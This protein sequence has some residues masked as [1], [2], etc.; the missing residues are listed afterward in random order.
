MFSMSTDL[1]L[2]MYFQ[3]RKLEKNYTELMSIDD[4][5][6]M[7]SC[8]SLKI[9]IQKKSIKMGVVIVFLLMS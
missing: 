5:A 1:T 3:F 8:I 6:L 4:V 9:V 2:E 7:H